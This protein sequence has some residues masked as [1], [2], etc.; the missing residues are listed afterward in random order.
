[1]MLRKPEILYPGRAVVRKCESCGG[2][3]QVMRYPYGTVTVKSTIILCIGVALLVA[4]LMFV[5]IK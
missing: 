1:M 4:A 5:S 3:A 2:V